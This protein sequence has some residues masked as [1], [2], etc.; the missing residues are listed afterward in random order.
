MLTSQT[1]KKVPKHL[2]RIVFLANSYNTE[3]YVTFIHTNVYLSLY[4]EL[5]KSRVLIGL[6]ECVIR[7]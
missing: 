1:R 3:L 2:A 6:E 4:N 5:C 7:V